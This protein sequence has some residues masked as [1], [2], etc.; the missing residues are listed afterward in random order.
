MGDA[1]V[2]RVSIPLELYVIIEE[3]IIKRGAL[4]Y[5]SVNDFVTKAVLEKLERMK[6]SPKNVKILTEPKRR[7][8]EAA[9]SGQ[10]AI[11]KGYIECPYCHSIVKPKS[12]FHWS[13][14]IIL[15][16]TNFFL[17]LMSFSILTPLFLL[18]FPLGPFLSIANLFL[19]TFIFLIGL[20]P[21]LLYWLLRHGKKKCPS[22][23]MPLG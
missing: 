21:G 7:E 8:K 14:F 11:P 5:S 22:R 23:G 1:E 20:I 17:F 2:K 13:V 15:L 4:R 9:P 19:S 12:R 3:K 16:L 18:N 10:E 6:L